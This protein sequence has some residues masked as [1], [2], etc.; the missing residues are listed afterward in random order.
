MSVKTSFKVIVNNNHLPV[1]DIAELFQ[2]HQKIYQKTKINSLT[3]FTKNFHAPNNFEILFIREVIVWKRKRDG[4]EAKLIS[5]TFR[6]AGDKTY[7]QT[8]IRE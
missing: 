3:E 1:K 4:D 6:D 8:F 5:P 2:I 7:T